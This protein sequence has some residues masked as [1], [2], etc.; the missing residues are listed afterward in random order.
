MTK[1][2]QTTADVEARAAGGQP[3]LPPGEPTLAPVTP[4]RRRRRWPWV[5]A[6]VIALFA[7]GGIASGVSGSGSGT[8]TST[9]TSGPAVAGQSSAPEA[10]PASPA[11]PAVPPVTVTYTTTRVIFK[12]DGTAPSG[13]SVMYGSDSDNRSPSDGLG[14]LEDGA[15]LPFTGSMRYDPSALY[16]FVTAQLEGGG[17]I[18]DRVILVKTTHYSDGSKKVERTLVA[19]GHASG[20]Y[21]IAQAEANN[22]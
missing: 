5:V 16:Y 22:F 2:Y 9:T 19:H 6:A 20:G 17:A 4:K 1:H 14:V 21:N 8:S 12:V 15:A 7:A 10:A 3:P 18:S 13:A 11:A